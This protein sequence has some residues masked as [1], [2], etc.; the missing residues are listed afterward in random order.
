MKT[1]SKVIAGSIVGLMLITMVA[2]AAIYI[3]GH[4]VTGTMDEVLSSSQDGMVGATATLIPN[5]DV[6]YQYL[7]SNSEDV[8]QYTIVHVVEVSNV[9]TN[10]SNPISYTISGDEVRTVVPANALDFPI[11]ITFSTAADSGLGTVTWAFSN[12]RVA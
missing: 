11:N 4:Q 6:V 1:K 12:D 3:A 9:P 7:V 2:A 8:E 10:A 5:T